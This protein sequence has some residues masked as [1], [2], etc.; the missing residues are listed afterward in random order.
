MNM[1]ANL[2][3]RLAKRTPYFH[4]YHKDDSLYMGRWWLFQTRW[5]SCRVH[6]IASADYDRHFH[7]HPFS[8]V[9][10]V[11]RGWYREQR[12]SQIQP[13]FL[14]DGQELSYGTDRKAWSTAYRSTSD[15]HLISE[16]S[17][18]GVWTLVFMSPKRQW[19]GFFTPSGKIYYKDYIGG[20]AK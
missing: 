10:I 3:I 2:I 11:L 9:S 6:H 8:F 15:R 18:G 14:S 17:P 5:L 20:D 19:W 4:L 7:D 13:C 1:I 16:V 12:P